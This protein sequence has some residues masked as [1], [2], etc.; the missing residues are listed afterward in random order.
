[1]EL[2]NV[3]SDSLLGQVLR[4]PLRLIPR[5]A[6]VRVLRGRLRGKHWIAG[7]L[8]YGCLLGEYEMEKQRVLLGTVSAGNVVYDLGAN[9]GFL[10]MLAS[11]LVGPAG[12]VYAFEPLPRNLLYL[13]K[14]VAMNHLENVEIIEAA[15]AASEGKARFDEDAHNGAGHVA[16]HGQIE[17]RTIG[18]DEMVASGALPPDVM[19]LDIE[20]GELEALQGA[21]RVLSES[22]PV[23]L[24]ATHGKEDR[25][26]RLGLAEAGTVHRG[27]IELLR[28]LD[29]VVEP[30]RR[31]NGKIW[32]PTELLATPR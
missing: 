22:R 2:S 7:S 27:C 18:L 4:A 19:K 29:Y 26:F 24:L 17:V 6:H 13:H 8:T 25:D 20:G 23:V 21:R 1:M 15:V 32:D 9:V 16:P 31:S 12:R 30:I 14:H 28:S 5:E 11:E 10:T 3:P